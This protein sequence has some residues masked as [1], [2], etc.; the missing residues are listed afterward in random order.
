MAF[1]ERSVCEGEKMMTTLQA[2]VCTN[3]CTHMRIQ[4]STGLSWDYENVGSVMDEQAKRMD[5]F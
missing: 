2:L 1:S 5:F 3:I 4:D